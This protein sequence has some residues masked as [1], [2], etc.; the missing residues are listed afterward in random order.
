MAG[1]MGKRLQPTSSVISKHLFPIYD[2][3]MIYYSLSLLLLARIKDIIVISDG[4]NLNLYKNL[5]GNGKKLGINISYLLQEKPEGIAQGILI[6]KDKIK[7]K[8]ICLVLGDNILYGNNLIQVLDQAKQRKKGATIFA[9][10]VDD[11]SSCGVVKFDKHLKAK[12]LVE[13][14]KKFISNYAIPGIY[15]YDENVVEI[16]ESIKKSRRG[17]YEITSINEVYLKKNMLNVS[18]LN[19][20]FAWLDTGTIDNLNA[21]SNFFMAIEKRQGLKISC[22]EEIALNNKWITRTKLLQLI[23]KMDAQSD[24]AKYLKKIIN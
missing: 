1:G 10:Y 20:G 15:F 3:P 8:K 6:S 5:L 16:A 17:E 21:A 2:K 18:V 23:N 14:P 9:Y 19:R 24:Y 11:P 12:K 22:L 4:K 13:K 7:N